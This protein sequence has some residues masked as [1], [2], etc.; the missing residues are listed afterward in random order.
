M[1]PEPNALI[2]PFRV[3]MPGWPY[4]PGTNNGHFCCRYNGAVLHV[5][6]SDGGGWD[7]VSVSLSHRCPTW[8]EMCYV[9]SLFFRD[10]ET[11]VQ[12][13]AKRSEYVNYHPY[14]LHWWRRQ[15]VEHELPPSIFVGPKKGAR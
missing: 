4:L 9:A 12:F 3:R 14:C 11:L 7:H 6:A 15:A 2:E 1:Y 10:S 8:E 5:M 13:R